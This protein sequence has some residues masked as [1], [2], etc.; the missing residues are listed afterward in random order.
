MLFVPEW[1]YDMLR[2]KYKKVQSLS[3]A[4]KL[5]HVLLL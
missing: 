4:H 2:K 3:E 1:F 5:Q